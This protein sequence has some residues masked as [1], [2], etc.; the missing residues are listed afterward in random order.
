MND[1]KGTS[2]ILINSA[3]GKELYENIKN[4]IIYTNEHIEDIIKYNPCISKSTY[5]NEK[6]EEFFIDLDNKSFE[7]LIDKYL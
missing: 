1:E 3:K 6:R 7:Y 4:S 2:A 5:Y